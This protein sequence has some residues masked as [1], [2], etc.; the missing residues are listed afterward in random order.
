MA[1][2]VLLLFRSGGGLRCS[3]S[4]RLLPLSDAA[5]SAAAGGGAAAVPQ[6]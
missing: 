1:E 3:L 5:L 6:R 4:L 2:V